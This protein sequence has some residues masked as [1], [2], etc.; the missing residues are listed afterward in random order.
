MIIEVAHVEMDATNCYDRIIPD[1]EIITS[2]RHGMYYKSATFIAIVLRELQ[3]HM[4]LLTVSSKNTSQILQKKITEQDK[5]H[6][7]ADQF[8]ETKTT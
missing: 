4:K 2:H 8:G 7:G 1:Q 5:V 3:H 6:H